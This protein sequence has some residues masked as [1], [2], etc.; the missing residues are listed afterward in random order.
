MTM[1]TKD[2]IISANDIITETISIPEW[3]GDVSIKVMSGTERDA[4]ESSIFEQKGKD[5]QRNLN[6]LRAKLVSKCLIDDKGSRLFS[7]KEIEIVGKK[8]AKV[9]DRLYEVCVRINGI[10]QKD[11]EDLTKNSE[12]EGKES[13]ISTS[14]ESSVKQ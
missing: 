8:S 6:N 2:Q 10:G 7:D 5:I 11:V 3:G 9:L 1:L 14:P 13:S 4:F 12:S